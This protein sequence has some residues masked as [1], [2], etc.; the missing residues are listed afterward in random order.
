MP[1]N[2]QSLTAALGSYT[3]ERKSD[4]FLIEL[5]QDDRPSATPGAMRAFQYFPESISDTKATNYQQKEIPGGSLPLYQW[6]NGGERLISFTAVFTSD[7]D[8]LNARAPSGLTGVL[9]GRGEKIQDRLKAAGELR[10]NVDIRAAVAWL[11]SYVLPSYANGAASGAQIGVPLTLAPAKV[12]LVLLGSG[13]GLAGGSTLSSPDAV[14][15]VMTQ[16]D[17]THEKF[18]PSGLPRVTTVGLAFAQIAQIGGRV[19]FPRRDKSMNEA[20]A[21]TRH[22][23]GYNMLPRSNRGRS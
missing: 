3:S 4:A 8:L 5:G 15:C 11:R 2:I 14:D 10:R 6:I 13:I 12:K 18:F 19:H 20:I 21:G 1:A 7:V 16:C 22:F 9:V 17:V 23:L